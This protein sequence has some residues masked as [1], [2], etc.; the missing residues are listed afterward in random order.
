MTNT[1]LLAGE[2]DPED[3]VKSVKKG[4][5]V[6]RIGGGNVTWV[7]GRFVFSVPEVYLIEDGK[8]TKPL[9]GIQLMGRVSAGP[10]PGLFF[11]PVGM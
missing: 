7:T 2:N 3:I 11:P 6:A 10:A 8:I 9:K 5:Y 4:I 1:Y